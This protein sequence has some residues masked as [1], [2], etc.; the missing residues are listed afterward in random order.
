MPIHLSNLRSHALASDIYSHGTQPVTV[1][2]LLRYPC[3]PDLL[4]STLASDDSCQDTPSRRP[5]NTLAKL[6]HLVCSFN[7]L[8]LQYMFIP[9]TS[10]FLTCVSPCKARDPCRQGFC[11]PHLNTPGASHLSRWHHQEELYLPGKQIFP[12]LPVSLSNSSH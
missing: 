2:S 6:E 5:C 4:V 9:C 10:C 11:P 1:P 12:I 7:T 3:S 8:H